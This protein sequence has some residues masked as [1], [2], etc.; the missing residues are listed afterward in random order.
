MKGLKFDWL[1][2]FM[3]MF[4]PSRRKDEKAFFILK[5]YFL[6]NHFTFAVS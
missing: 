4:K 6:K 5:K 2:V 3:V 1:I